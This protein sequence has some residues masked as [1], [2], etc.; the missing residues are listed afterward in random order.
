MSSSS[1]AA[2]PNLRPVTDQVI[3]DHKTGVYCNV[4]QPDNKEFKIQLKKLRVRVRVR[5]TDIQINVIY[6][7]KYPY[8]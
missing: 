5:E 1:Y 6:T 2:S 3:S 7:Y 4:L 8:A